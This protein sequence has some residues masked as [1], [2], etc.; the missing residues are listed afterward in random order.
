MEVHSAEPNVVN[1]NGYSSHYDLL[2]KDMECND[3]AVNQRSRGLLFMPQ[4]NVDAVN[5]VSYP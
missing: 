1:Y 4:G 2:L 5:R 3:G